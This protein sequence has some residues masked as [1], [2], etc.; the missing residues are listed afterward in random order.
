[1]LGWRNPTL[2]LQPG[3][4]CTPSGDQP[5]WFVCD[6]P[7]LGSESP[8]SQ[9]CPGWLVTVA[10]VTPGPVAEKAE[11]PDG[12]VSGQPGRPFQLH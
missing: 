3:L 6:L 1:M 10:L 8:V 4:T 7:S 11:W 12:A 2:F 9:F 5:S